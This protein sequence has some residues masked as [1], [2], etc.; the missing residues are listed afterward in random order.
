MALCYD[1]AMPIVRVDNKA[2]WEVASFQEVPEDFL[3]YDF[4]VSQ[5][6]L[7][8]GI[9]T[10][11]EAEK[12]LRPALDQLGDPYLL[13]DFAKA[14]DRIRLAIEKKEWIVVYGDYDVD[15]V[16]SSTIL[17]SV[18]KSLGGKV[19]V[20]LPER[21]KEGYGLNI[22]ALDQLKQDGADLVVAVDNGTA[23]YEQIAHANSIGLDVV[24]VD[25]HEPH[26]EIPPAIAVV[27]PKLQG[28]Q[29]PFRECCAAGVSYHVARALVGEEKAQEYLDLAAVG[30]VAD[31][32]PLVADNRILVIE[33]LKV[34]NK[35]NRFGIQALVEV[36]GMGG[37]PL[38]VYSIG[39]QLGPRL[40]AAG[41]IDHA[42]LAF[43]LLNA[44]NYSQ[45][46][47]LAKDL[48]NLNTRR[49]EMTDTMLV[50][51]K[52]KQGEFAK[53]KIILV[54]GE[55]WSIG[56]AGIVAGRL[57]EAYSK[58]AIVF[59]Y[60]T[61][62]CKGSGRSVDD[63]NIVELLNEVADKLDHY[64]GHAKA[65]GLSVKKEKFSDFKQLLE[66]K[67]MEMISDD[68]LLPKVKINVRLEVAHVNSQLL[69]EIERF[70][71]FGFGNQ[72]PVFCVMG[73][74]HLQCE[75]V[76]A[77]ARFGKIIFH[78]DEGRRMEV[79][80]WDKWEELAF[81]LE[82]GEHYDVA[83]TMSTNDWN[84][85]KFMQLKLVAIRDSATK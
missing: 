37:K 85:R 12:F 81:D 21:M 73:V 3:G 53:Q 28:S 67:A 2:R 82:A 8:R 59:E 63:V 31:V 77:G 47:Q 76:G 41:R 70:A 49:Q 68:S 33:G 15:G 52:A 11:E 54:G 40:N 32:V 25:H 48:N 23:A 74:T 55:G 80:C 27:N 14:I 36:A 84:G 7:Q 30:T 29:Y 22:P 69:E 65:A 71:P 58:P 51:A 56:V 16:T 75:P 38:D 62:Y 44:A 10:K 5:L 50:S 4:V 18:I 6:L 61:E 20:Y 34:L 13:P 60:Q 19:S 79:M 64:G 78:D 43:D 9:A 42:R 35:T 45:A 26:G 57:V 72:T 83:F 66:T 24:V 39:F 46:L 17:I 1:D